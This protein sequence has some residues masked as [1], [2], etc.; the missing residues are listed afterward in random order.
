MFASGT[1]ITTKLPLWQRSA[2]RVIVPIAVIRPDFSAHQRGCPLISPT[3]RPNQVVPNA[4]AVLN[5]HVFGE[6]LLV[7]NLKLKC[8]TERASRIK[9]VKIIDLHSYIIQKNK[10]LI[11]IIMPTRIEIRYFSCLLPFASLYLTNRFLSFYILY[12][13]VPKICPIFIRS[14][15]VRTMNRGHRDLLVYN[16]IDDITVV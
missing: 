16:A 6:N 14:R 2:P 3:S 5:L 4:R 10:C 13:F 12:N 11:I 8:Y 15:N 1:T 9:M 7:N